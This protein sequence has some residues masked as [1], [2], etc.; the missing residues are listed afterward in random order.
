MNLETCNGF[1]VSFLMQVLIYRVDFIPIC[2]PIFTSS[3]SRPT[4]VQPRVGSRVESGIGEA[5]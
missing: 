4:Q 5:M 3:Y 1:Y 2:I